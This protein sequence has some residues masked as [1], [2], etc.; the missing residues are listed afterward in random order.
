MRARDLVNR[1]LGVVAV[2]AAANV[3]V[4]VASQNSQVHQLL[5]HAE[6][7]GTATHLF[8]GDSVM[9]SGLDESA[10]AG[11]L[12]GSRPVSLALQA[13][14]TVEHDLLYRH[15]GLQ[16]GANVVYGF[17]DT[18]LTDRPEASWQDMLE[19]RAVSLM[20]DPDAALDMYAIDS[21]AAVAFLATRYVPMLVNRHMIWWQV[22]RLRRAAEQVGQPPQAA[23]KFG[24]AMDFGALE[25]DP[26]AFGSR[27][28]NDVA[29]RRPLSRPVLDILQ[30]ASANRN[31]VLVVLMPATSLHR[32]RCYASAEWAAY[33]AYVRQRVIDAGGSFLDASA[34]MPDE[35]FSD[36]L[37]I[38][39]EWALDFSA[40]LA[41]RFRQ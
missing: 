10:F 3:A 12:P 13:T 6:M 31:P 35:A 8:L 15:R 16:P 11:A 20:L 27:V 29:T 41:R 32:A 19:H 21:W 26:V 38:R 25:P 40:R 28:A 7:A 30:R 9:A 34:W 33:Q 37:H 4:L 23:S 14:T 1:C 2:L 5:R 18:R 36:G 24:R 17:M 22:E 39:S